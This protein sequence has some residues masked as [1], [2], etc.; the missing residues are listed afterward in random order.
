MSELARKG[1][2]Q[3]REIRVVKAPTAAA[4][5]AFQNRRVPKIGAILPTQEDR[6]KALEEFRQFKADVAASMFDCVQNI[7]AVEVM[8]RDEAELYVEEFQ[9][10]KAAVK[11]MLSYTGAERL[12]AVISFADAKIKTCPKTRS[13]IENTFFELASASVGFLIE[14]R[15]GKSADVKVYGKRYNVAQEFSKAPETTSIIS[16]IDDLIQE[17]TVNSRR[18]YEESFNALSRMAGD[19][20]LSVSELKAGKEGRVLLQV[21]DNQFRDRT[22]KGGYILVESRQSIIR[23]LGAVSGPQRA[24]ENVV[25]TL[26]YVPVGALVEERMVFENR[27][28]EEQFKACCILHTW[29][30]L[31]IK[32]VEEES[33]KEN[34]KAAFAAQVE[35]ER[36]QL[37]PKGTISIPEFV[38]NSDSVG[39]AFLDFGRKPFEIRNDGNIIKRVWEVFAVVERNNKGLIRVAHCPERLEEFFTENLEFKNPGQDFRN[40]GRLGQI[41]RKKAGEIKNA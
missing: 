15:E 29:L 3:K 21:P 9:Q 40:L 23:L 19:N 8:S 31:A 30:K 17:T 22:Y 5:F 39:L 18:I 41:L 34:R 16:Q 28:D 33:E 14:A 35:S 37:I 2:I 32:A 12:V 10:S 11:E 7:R 38:L 25:R 27:L 1:N 13:A 26:G 20:Q 24:S 4:R 6:Q 36:K